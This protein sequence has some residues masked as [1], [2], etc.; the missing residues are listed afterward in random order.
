[1][2]CVIDL[3]RTARYPLAPDTRAR[4]WSAH[5]VAGANRPSR[6]TTSTCEVR[7][8]SAEKF[9][10]KDRK[11]STHPRL[12]ICDT[13]RS[14]RW[15]STPALPSQRRHC[16]GGAPHWVPN[17]P[18]GSP[19]RRVG[20]A[21]INTVRV[22]RQR[23]GVRVSLWH[24]Q[25]NGHARIRPVSENRKRN[26]ARSKHRRGTRRRRRGCDL[27]SERKFLIRE[28]RANK[29]APV[30]L[31]QVWCMLI[32]IS[33]PSRLRTGTAASVVARDGRLTQLFRARLAGF[34]VAEAAERVALLF[35]V[36]SLCSPR[37]G[38]RAPH[39]PGSTRSVSPA[40]S[41]TPDRSPARIGTIEG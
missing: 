41:L 34:A 25:R 7:A 16:P 9:I 11:R 23:P 33:Q 14:L 12:E 38:Y 1:M 30:L 31:M 8:E 10:S 21:P 18:T 28:R 3:P 5:P 29:I 37:H 36:R 17:V 26:D 19:Q 2:R 15:L 22:A 24:P 39:P 13:S 35:V 32:I 6:P 4:L 27:D 40:R 20:G